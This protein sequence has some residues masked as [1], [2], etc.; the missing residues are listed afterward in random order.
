MISGRLKYRLE[1]Y[2]PTVERNKFGNGV[3]TYKLV[4]TIHAERVKLTGRRSEEVGEH[5]PDYSAR[6]NIY[7]AHE[8]AENWRVKEVGGNTYTVVA[9]EPNID[10]GMKTLICE[11]L[12]D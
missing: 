5:F 4:K 7:I 10:R 3:T 2:R 8:V 12:N 6:Y 9:V 1:T 11:R